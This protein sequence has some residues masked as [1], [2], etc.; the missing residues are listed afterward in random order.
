L[1]P[2]L[3]INLDFCARGNLSNA[4]TQEPSAA[5]TTGRADPGGTLAV[6]AAGTLLVL[7]AFTTPL[8]TLA[9]TAAGLGAGPGAQ[10]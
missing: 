4:M 1:I 2:R 6:A 8:T 3:T 7:V 5:V 10:A 9:N